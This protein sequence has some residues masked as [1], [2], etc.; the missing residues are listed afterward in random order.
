MEDG[1]GAI[2]RK[3]SCFREVFVWKIS[4][5]WREA[6]FAMENSKVDKG[7]KDPERTTGDQKGPGWGKEVGGKRLHPRDRGRDR[8]GWTPG[9]EKRERWNSWLS[10]VTEELGLS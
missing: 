7:D 3:S 8:I 5:G 10:K 4:A 2:S 6:G 9:K 1:L